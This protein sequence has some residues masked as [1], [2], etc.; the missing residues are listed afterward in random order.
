[1]TATQA[2]DDVDPDVERPPTRPRRTLKRRLDN[3]TLRWQARLD[4]EWADR[5]LPWLLA[6]GLLVV[7]LSLS[8]ARAR[9]LNGGVDLGRYTQA[10]FLIDNGDEPIL[11]VK[12]GT[13]LLSQQAS[14]LFYPMAWVTKLAPIIPVLLVLQSAALALGV[15]PLWRIGRRLANLRVGAVLALTWAYAFYPAVHNLNLGDFH[16]E[17]VAVPA[18]LFAALFGLSRRWILYALACAVAVAARADLVL[19]VGGF[20]ALLIIEGR[21]R[22]GLLSIAAAAAYTLAAVFVIQP[23][24]GDGTYAHID[25]FTQYGD[26]PF[27]VLGGMVSNPV[28]FLEDLTV[29]QNF[30]VVVFLLAPVFF[31]PVLA[32]RYLLPVLPLE[33]LYLVADVEI[34]ATFREQTV[35]ITAFV[36]VATAFA[37]AKIGRQG[38]ERVIVDRRVLGALVLMSTVFFVRD[39]DASPYRRP[40]TWGGR[41][42]A[43]Q[44]RLDAVDLMEGDAGASVRASPALV[45]L[46]AERENIYVLDTESRPNVRAAITMPAD[47]GGPAADVGEGRIACVD[48]I[49]YDEHAATDWT[50]NE[51]RVF[52][53]GLG[54]EGYARVFATRGIEV[55]EGDPETSPSCG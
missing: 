30:G 35:A 13:H 11:T 46:L 49:L 53:E 25:S 39:A 42:L 44:A 29:E 31:L 24:F 28:Q 47:E 15:V 5:V 1:M 37:L 16:P 41:D 33:I 34:E 50:D 32:P 51:R 48:W 43:D 20:G 6:G 14:F 52:R 8:L 54:R 4:S 45:P 12:D 22:A 40:W 9:S 17:S 19:V 2:R 7:F 10:A 38:V 18:L 3:A 27:G 21:R 36:F 26:T 55:Y 23:G